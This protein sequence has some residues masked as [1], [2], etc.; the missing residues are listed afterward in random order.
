MNDN[1]LPNEADFT[2]HYIEGYAHAAI[3][4]GH[5]GQF[6]APLISHIEGNLYMGGC[7]HGV[8]LP[9]DFYKVFS[10]YPWEQYQLGS[11]TDRVEIRLYDSAEIPDESQLNDIANQVVESL[12]HGKT[13]VHCQAGLNRSGLISAIVLIKLGRTPEQAIALLREKRHAVVLCN[14]T[15]ETWLLDNY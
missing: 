9:D 14:T 12:A 4:A 11:R 5:D 2:T 3:E 6:R 7:I 1:S 10:L 8:T 15:F 13:L